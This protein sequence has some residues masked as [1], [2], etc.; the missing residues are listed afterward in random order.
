MLN[1]FSWIFLSA[2]VL[3]NR[4]ADRLGKRAEFEADRRAVAMGFGRELATAL[5]RVEGNQRQ[6]HMDFGSALRDGL[7]QTHPSPRSR[8]SRIEALRRQAAERQRLAR[9]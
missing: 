5:R 3:S 6:T 9:S 8:V 1:G 4:I 2:L 7:T